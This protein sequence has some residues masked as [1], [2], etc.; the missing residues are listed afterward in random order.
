MLNTNYQHILIMFIKYIRVALKTLPSTPAQWLCL[1]EPPSGPLVG[2]RADHVLSHLL[3]F[4][5]TL[6]SFATQVLLVR[7]GSDLALAVKPQPLKRIQTLAGIPLCP[8]WARIS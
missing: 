3:T 7:A 1:H 4:A 8:I 5:Q 6:L 2:S